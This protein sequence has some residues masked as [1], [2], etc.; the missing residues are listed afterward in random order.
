MSFDEV[1][2]TMAWIFVAALVMV[3]FCKAPNV[4]GAPAA[5]AH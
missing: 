1:F 3:P 4:T 2:R 5:E